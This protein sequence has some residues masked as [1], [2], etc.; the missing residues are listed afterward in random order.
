M[1]RFIC[2]QSVRYYPGG[3]M[4]DFKGDFDSLEVAES[5]IRE[6]LQVDTEESDFQILDCPKR[7]VR[8]FWKSNG[9]IQTQATFVK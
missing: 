8:T 5:Y 2:F 4:E 1:K 6:L 3:G 9:K 7:E